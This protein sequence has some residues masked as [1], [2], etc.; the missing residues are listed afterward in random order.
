VDC[1]SFRRRVNREDEK[2]NKKNAP[3]VQ[4]RNNSASRKSQTPATQIE[5]K[6]TLKIANQGGTNTGQMKKVTLAKKKKEFRS[7]ISYT[8]HEWNKKTTSNESDETSSLG[9]C[10]GDGGKAKRGKRVMENSH[11]LLGGGRCFAAPEP[12]RGE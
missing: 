8:G 11:N 5:K 3:P 6:P 7:K 4:T 9:R 12:Q 10:S 1:G 2:I